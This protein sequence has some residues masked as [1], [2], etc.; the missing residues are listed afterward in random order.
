MVEIFTKEYIKGYFSR[1][2]KVILVALAIFL[3]FFVIGII[4][5]NI[6]TGDNYG[7]ITKELSKSNVSIPF[8]EVSGGAIG[9]F[10]HNL[11]VDLMIFIGG[12]LFSI[13]SVLLIIFNAVAIGV[14][15]GGDFYF[16]CLSIIPHFIFEY[17][18]GSVFTLTG[19]FL[20]TKLEIDVIKKRSFKEAVSDSYILKDILFSLIL[21]VIFLLIAAVIEAYVTPGIVIAAFSK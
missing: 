11:S 5:G 16:A 3:V 2:K 10:I 9:L 1:N 7:S 19:A 20:I 8:S 12:F 15:F 4:V 21:T 18:G 13:I 17:L 6:Q 14:P